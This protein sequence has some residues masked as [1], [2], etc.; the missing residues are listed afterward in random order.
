MDFIV[1]LHAARLRNM[2]KHQQIAL[3]KDERSE[4][5]VLIHSGN[6]PARKQTRARILL[7]TDRSEGRK[8]TDQ[9]V[10]EAAMCSVSTVRSIRR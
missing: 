6:A 3:D 7:L 2:G 10:A 1:S 8:R 5:E 9:E 4:L